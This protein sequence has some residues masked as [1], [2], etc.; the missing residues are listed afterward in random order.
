MNITPT[1]LI[2]VA[3]QYH[4]A[5]PKRLRQY[6]NGRGIP[7]H[8]IN[9]HIL[10]WNGWRITIPIYNQQG[11]VVFFKLAKAPEDSRPAP[12]M[13]TSPG[14]GVELYGWDR[15]LQKPQQIIICEGEFD[16]LVLEAQ[17]FF[18]VTS[19]GGAATFRPE[20]AKAIRAIPQVYAC[21]DR[22]QAGLN[23]T[24]VVTLMIPHAKVVELPAEVGESGDITDYFV[25]LKRSPEEFV[26]LLEAAHPAKPRTRQERQPRS[27]MQSTDSLLAKRIQ[28]IKSAMPIA[29]II[30]QYVDLRPSGRT[31]LGRCP[32]HDDRTP[33]FVI[34]PHSETFHCFGCR[35]HGD[36]ISFVQQM[37]GMSFSQALE[38]LDPSTSLNGNQFKQDQSEG[39]AA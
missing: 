31:L 1:N 5:L 15:V 8:I 24:M 13:L 21:F 9:S 27:P 33:S 16:R 26:R 3:L 4:D 29:E 7:D 20:W 37:E 23:G 28:R 14:G 32:F 34:Y 25:R 36:V 2:D 35:A 10:G 30:G 17:G 39:Q 19:T 22:D 12:K 6:L 11:E 18:A 38:A